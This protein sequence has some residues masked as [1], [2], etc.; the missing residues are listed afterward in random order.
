[1]I[2]AS[3]VKRRD[4]RLVRLL[5]KV[6]WWG[7]PLAISQVFKEARVQ[8]RVLLVTE[9]R[10][11]IH[12]GRDRGAVIEGVELRRVLMMVLRHLHRGHARRFEGCM[13]LLGE[14]PCRRVPYP[15][16]LIGLNFL[17]LA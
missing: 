14:E 8:V 17:S 3:V 10:R 2:G 4:L 6:R 15:I 16:E 7:S 1:M 5:C 12:E 13:V 11:L 9:G